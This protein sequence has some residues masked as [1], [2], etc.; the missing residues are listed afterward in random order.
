MEIKG[1]VIICRLVCMPHQ[2]HEPKKLIALP[3]CNSFGFAT[4]ITNLNVGIIYRIRCLILEA[5]FSR[6]TNGLKQPTCS[7]LLVKV[8]PGKDRF[9]E[10][11]TGWHISAYFIRTIAMEL[12]FIWEIRMITC[13]HKQHQ[14]LK[15][16]V[17]PISITSL[18]H[19]LSALWYNCYELRQREAWF[20][21]KLWPL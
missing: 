16:E 18:S 7:R 9:S 10:W 1:R 20:N 13:I 19:G 5:L 21:Y 3:P 17:A 14:H 4:G 12:T 2:L 15:T 11:F 6:H 8:S